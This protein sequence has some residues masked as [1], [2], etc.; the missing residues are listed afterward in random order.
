[1]TSSRLF[2][3]WNDGDAASVSV[4]VLTADDGSLTVYSWL[5]V[6]FAPEDMVG[7]PPIAMILLSTLVTVP[8]ALMKSS[9]LSGR[10]AAVV[11]KFRPEIVPEPPGVQEA[12]AV[13][14]RILLP[15]T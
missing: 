1:M 2:P 15:G 13:T 8:V 12:P 9:R 10:E 3:L 5:N 14:M 6:A 11:L 4:I 7:T